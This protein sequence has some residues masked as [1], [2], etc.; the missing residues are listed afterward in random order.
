MILRSFMFSSWLCGALFVSAVNNNKTPERH[1]KEIETLV[2]ERK[3]AGDYKMVGRAEGLPSGIYFCRLRIGD[4]IRTK[5]L[6][7]QK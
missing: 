1:G 4:V 2:H 7:L 5:K 6:V 3:S